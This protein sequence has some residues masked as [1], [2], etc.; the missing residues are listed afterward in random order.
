M[1][2]AIFTAILAAVLIGAA[3]PTQAAE[4]QQISKEELERICEEAGQEFG[5]CPE[6]LEAIVEKESNCY[7][8]AKNED[9]CGLCQISSKWHKERMAD[10]GVTDIYDPEGNIRT[11]ASYLA[12]LFQENE[13]VV[14]CLMRYNMKKSTADQLY[15]EGKFTD[16]ALTICDRSAQLEREHGK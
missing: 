13:D 10:L 9:C 11:A 2:K 15:R 3:M 16:Y 12:E 4:K 8:Y 5:I 6:L 7:I 14:Y 1:K